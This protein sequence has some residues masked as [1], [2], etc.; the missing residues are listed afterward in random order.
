MPLLVS[1]LNV[2]NLPLAYVYQRRYLLERH[3][4]QMELTKRCQGLATVLVQKRLV[5]RLDNH[6]EPNA[7]ER[8]A[9]VLPDALPTLLPG[10]AAQAGHDCQK[11]VE[12]PWYRVAVSL[13]SRGH[14]EP[15]GLQLRNAAD[16]LG[17]THPRPMRLDL[18]G[19]IVV[20]VSL[21]SLFDQVTSDAEGEKQRTDVASQAQAGRR[22][23]RFEGR[24]VPGDRAV[25]L[26]QPAQKNR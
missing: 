25:A 3:L 8:D 10:H 21:S 20:V 23:T 6:H 14:L 13:V 4:S 1:G 26:E 17:E 7:V 5:C 2:V 16:L 24:L 19:V 9:H 22:V 11:T 18:Y 12:L 15:V